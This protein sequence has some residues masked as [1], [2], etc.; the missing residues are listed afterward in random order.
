[1]FSSSIREDPSFA[2]E[3][4]VTVV[5]AIS[6]SIAGAASAATVRDHFALRGTLV[7]P[8]EI[9][10]DGVIRISAGRI[11]SVSAE[12]SADAIVVDGVIFPGLVDL[13]NHLTWNVLPRWTPSVRFGNR[14][15]WQEDPEYATSLSGPHNTLTAAGL[16]CDMNRYAEIKAIVNGATAGVGG[17]P[18]PAENG[19]VAGLLRNLDLASDLSADRPVN[20]ERLRNV[21][22][23]FES[24]SPR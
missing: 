24:E 19:C 3:R 20:A 16:G 9:I 11:Q 23:P 1:M 18:N 14:Y 12:A 5:V 17:F 13:H 15:E 10:A 22:Y 21:V 7:T 8:T 6:A 2:I 4:T